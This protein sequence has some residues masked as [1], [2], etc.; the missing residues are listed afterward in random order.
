MAV[1]SIALRKAKSKLEPFKF[2]ATSTIRLL[3]KLPSLALLCL[4]LV[5]S[6]ASN[7]QTI[8]NTETDL[9]LLKQ[10]MPDADSFSAKQG[11][12]PVFEAYRHN[13]ESGADELMGYAFLTADLPPE[14]IGYSG[15]INV[16]V[17]MDLSGTLSSIKVIH[18]NESYMSIRGDFLSTEGF[19]RQFKNKNISEGFRVGRDVDGVSRA[20][21]TSWAVSR[22]IRNAARRVTRA[23]IQDPS[24]LNSQGATALEQIARLS[25]QEMI[26]IGLVRKQTIIMDDA[27]ELELTYAFIGEEALGELM[28]GAG[29]YSR[30]EREASGRVSEGQML[31]VGIGGNSSTPFRQERLALQQGEDISPLPRRRFVYVG[32]AD[33][34]RL[35]DQMRFAGAIVL[36]SDI[37]ITRPFSIIYSTGSGL[38]DRENLHA[39]EYTLPDVVLAQVQG[40]PFEDPDFIP[41][42]FVDEFES[43]EGLARLL[44]AVP[45]V[46]VLA[47]IGLLSLVMI[48]FLRKSSRL[49]WL[50]LVLTLGY[51]GFWDGGFL[52]VSHI[53]NA[54]KVGP[55]MFLNDLPILIIVVFTLITTLLWGRV[56]CS[57]LCPFGALQDILTRIM[58]KRTQ[59]KVPQAIHDKALYIKYVILAFII[60]MAL[61]QSDLSV[62]QYFE[63]F[64]TL[65]YRST[66]VLLWVILIALLLASAVVKRFYCR[67]ACPLG[68]SLGV[69]SLL[70][71]PFRIKRVAQCDICKVCEHACPTGAIRSAEIDFKECVRC[72]VCEIKLIDE[73]G[74][75]QHSVEKLKGKLNQ[76]QPIEVVEV[77]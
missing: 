47:L 60:V 33:A 8:S 68:A 18:Y 36:T 28:V 14:E 16:L 4:T 58:P 41:A 53:I 35:K 70:A 27:S 32:S 13:A 46:Q 9:A 44:E 34:G 26:D 62:F 11:Q 7:A 74:V 24:K 12:P 39:L 67:Y 73:A 19:Q 30:A 77:A 29:D 6:L 1:L 54:M 17:G 49:R 65:F 56:F 2:S 25:W 37:D 72:D 52:S 57:S 63:P 50:T 22:G 48:S 45:W 21:I 76:W 23:Y 59:V 66:S 5:I 43:P 3:R 64:G 61:V 40:L 42:E 15:P 55:S 75:C 51:L 69:L 71:A 20:S 10:L 38:D 31:L